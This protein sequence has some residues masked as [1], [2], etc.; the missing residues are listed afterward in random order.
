M[1]VKKPSTPE[2]TLG[3]EVFWVLGF[4]G[5]SLVFRFKARLDGEIFCEC[6]C[7]KNG[8]CGCHETVHM[9]RPRCICVCDVTHE[10][11]AYPFCAIV[12]CH[13]SMYQYR[14]QSHHVNKQP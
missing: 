13:S 6:D 7:D 8:L 10:W 2:I 12:M 14:L 5:L 11:V 4:S 9:V 3:F 1:F